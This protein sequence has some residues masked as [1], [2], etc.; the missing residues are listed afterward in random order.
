MLV[1]VLHPD[2]TNRTRTGQVENFQPAVSRPG[3]RLTDGDRQNELNDLD[4]RLDTVIL[5]LFYPT[6]DYATAISDLASMY[7][8]RIKWLMGRIM[9][10]TD[11]TGIKLGPAKLKLEDGVVVLLRKNNQ[12]NKADHFTRIWFR[13]GVIPY[14]TYQDILDEVVPSTNRQN[15]SG[16]AGSSRLVAQ[17]S[18]QARSQHFQNAISREEPGSDIESKRSR[19]RVVKECK[20]P[21]AQ[22]TCIIWLLEGYVCVPK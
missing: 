14:K 2:G 13:A 6:G 17:T 19:V 11:G 21:E 8:N 12:R 16:K 7:N 3:K 15:M 9:S 5:V 1:V 4:D 10:Y 22:P 18:R 20:P